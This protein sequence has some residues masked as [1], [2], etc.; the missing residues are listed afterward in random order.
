M[1][2]NTY[3]ASLG[4]VCEIIFWQDV[5]WNNCRHWP[6]NI[7]PEQLVPVWH[8]VWIYPWKRM[9]TPWPQAMGRRVSGAQSSLLC[10]NH[11][12][13]SG[14]AHPPFSRFPRRQL[15]PQSQNLQWGLTSFHFHSR[16]VW[17]VAEG[18]LV[19]L[20]DGSPCLSP[21]PAPWRCN[22]PRCCWAWTA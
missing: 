11:Y 1:K 3:M 9:N 13:S 7:L 14:A 22:K 21:H 19:P 18:S 4:F 10:H 16:E 17:G 6:L 15:F 12:V 5:V 8:R 2:G 20:I